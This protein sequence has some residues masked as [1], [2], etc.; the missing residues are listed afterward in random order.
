[1]RSQRGSEVV[2]ATRNFHHEIVKVGFGIA[3]DIM[4]NPATFHRGNDMFH[5]DTNTSNHRVFGFVFGTEFVPS[6]FFLGLIGHDTVRLKALETCIL[7]ED[8]AWWKRI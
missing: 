1:M 3:K 5:Q 4:H 2:Q 6:W 7:K 8:T